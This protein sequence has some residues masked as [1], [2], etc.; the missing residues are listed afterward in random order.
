MKK[1]PGQAIYDRT[2]TLQ[3]NLARLKKGGENFEVNI[4]PDKAVEYKEGKEVD[5]RD[6]LKAEDIFSSCKK[7]LLASE[8]LMKTV[9]GTSDPIGVAKVILDEGEIQFTSEF[10]SKLRAQKRKKIIDLIH[11]NAIDPKSNL[12]HPPQRIENAMDEAK[13]VIND[14]KTAEDQ[15]NDVI[16]GIRAVL[17]IKFEKRVISIMMPP[18][19]AGRGYP[20]VQKFGT[21]L[22]DSWN[23]DGSWSCKIEIPA[24]LQEELFDQLNN[25]TSGTVDLKI[26]ESK[27]E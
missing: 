27:G 24:G 15:I 23:N 17:P 26:L 16:K 18:E 8:N 22:E 13:I 11:R 6:V 3:L 19:H 10:R 9:F 21:I 4:D 14:L 20:I 7:G 12:P 5:I 25:L 1:M 2:E